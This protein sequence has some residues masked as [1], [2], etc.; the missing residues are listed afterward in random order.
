MLKYK[1][2]YIS[3]VFDRIVYK[4]LNFFVES[5]KMLHLSRKMYMIDLKSM[6]SAQKSTIH[7]KNSESLCWF[8]DFFRLCKEFE[9]EH[10][11]GLKFWS[12]D[13][14]NTYNTEPL[15]TRRNP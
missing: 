10:S 9:P 3:I 8:H 2:Y 15:V 14:K 4:L 13:E 12:G 7:L 11:E 5:W 6:R 1:N